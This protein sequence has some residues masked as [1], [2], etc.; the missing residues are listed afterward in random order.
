MSQH[1][2]ELIARPGALRG[3]IP[4]MRPGSDRRTG[5][6]NGLRSQHQSV[7]RGQRGHLEPGVY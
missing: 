4:A 5:G 1:Q 7:Q 2:L 6:V 3:F